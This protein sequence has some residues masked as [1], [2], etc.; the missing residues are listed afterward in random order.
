MATIGCSSLP[1]V[2]LLYKWIIS[3]AEVLL[4]N[5]ESLGLR[6]PEFSIPLQSTT[7]AA[8]WSL[9][10]SRFGSAWLFSQPPQRLQLDMAAPLGGG[11]V[12]LQQLR[13]S[14]TPSKPTPPAYE[15]SL[16]QGDSKKQHVEGIPLVGYIRGSYQVVKAPV[17]LISNCVFSILNSETGEQLHSIK[18]SQD[19]SK[20]SIDDSLKQCVKVELFELSKYLFN[21]TLTIQVSAT[22]LCISDPTKTTLRVGCDVPPDNVRG[23]MLNLYRDKALVDAG[24]KSG[25]KVFKVHK[26]I[27]ASQS[28]VFRK[29]FEVDMREKR[30]GVIKISDPDVSPELVSDLVTYLY[31]GD[32]PGIHTRAK[33]LLKVAHLYEIP[34]LLRMCENELQK[35]ITASNVCNLLLLAELHAA[36]DLKAKCMEFIHLN[37]R[38]VHKTQGWQ[39]LKD[40][41]TDLLFEA[42]ESTFH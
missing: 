19:N 22:L 37:S 33:E 40:N 3:D 17:V 21:G 16:C 38:S 4:E 5:C 27:L 12:Q 11:G 26:A 8:T 30:S 24:I 7:E 10:I 23:D 31:T 29:M 2:V 32:A 25:E 34:R 41:E 39:D 9:L 13:A 35:S 36:Q 15:L 1:K 14:T 18:P 28:P 42:V 20:C 6:S